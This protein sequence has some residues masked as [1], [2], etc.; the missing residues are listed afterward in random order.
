MEINGKLN[1]ESNLE[2]TEQEQILKLREELHKHNYNYYVLNMPTI[3][4]KDFDMMMH[5]LQD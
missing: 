5:Q 1:G 4:D 3:S 2:L